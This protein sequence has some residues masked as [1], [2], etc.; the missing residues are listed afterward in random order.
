MRLK[1]VRRRDVSGWIASGK[2]QTD[3]DCRNNK[4]QTKKNLKKGKAYGS[5][6]STIRN[7][8]S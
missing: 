5:K 7:Q 8:H 3:A 4:T 2:R 1:V 6:K